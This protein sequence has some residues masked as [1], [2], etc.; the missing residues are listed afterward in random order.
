[1]KD[2]KA[3]QA[4][5]SAMDKDLV[6]AVDLGGTQIRVALCDARGNIL[7]R[8]AQPACAA[9]GIE[10]VFARIVAN[11]HAATSDWSRVRGIGVGAPGT[12]DPWRGVI[13]EAPNLAGMVAFPIRARLENE[14]RAP[15]F[16]GNDANLAALGEQRYGAGRGVANLIYVTIGTGIG[17][18]IVANDRLFLG[19]RGFAGEVGH[20]T[21]QAD[22]PRCNCGNVGCLEALAAGPAI[23]RAARD[24]LRAGRASQMRALSDDDVERVTGRIVT[25]AARDGDALAREILARAGF[26]IGLGLVSLQHNFDTRL[27][28]LGGGV[29]I[30]AWDFIY[31]SIHNTF[32]EYTMPSMRRDVRIV[33]AQLGDDAGLLG[34]AALVNDQMTNGK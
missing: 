23:A 9:E 17:G 27:F 2:E 11:I 1:M 34:A 25:H 28:V 15:V 3:L 7:K 30:N 33:P 12:V 18:G 32:D 31:P 21:L 8:I 10:A 5:R 16:V 22:G 26:Y 13:L 19:A 6:V 4:H 20:Q 24:A 29:A 14:L